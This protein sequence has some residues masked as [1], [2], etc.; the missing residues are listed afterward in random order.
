MSL[1]NCKWCG[2]TR[3]TKDCGGTEGALWCGSTDRW[4]SPQCEQQQ[5]I[6]ELTAQRD[7][8]LAALQD[9]VG[10]V[11]CDACAF[12]EQCETCRAI[13]A[14]ARAAIARAKEQP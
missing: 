3:Q 1:P 14:P 10:Q 4:Q 5:E 2:A 9:L 7:E 11:S 8:L 12:T 13:T 6:N